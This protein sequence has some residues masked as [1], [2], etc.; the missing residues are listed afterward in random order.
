LVIGIIF[1]EKIRRG[2]ILG[3]GSSAVANTWC[4]RF[5]KVFRGLV[6]LYPLSV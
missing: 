4:I 2:F 6:L 5:R 1:V 3:V